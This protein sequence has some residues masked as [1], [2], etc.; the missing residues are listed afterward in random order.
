MLD[1]DE[2]REAAAHA[3]DGESDVR[4]R[5]EG[6]PHARYLCS[7]GPEFERDVQWCA[8]LDRFDQVAS[9]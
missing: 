9:L 3:P 7:L 2:A 6:A 8:T 4:A 5:V 1:G